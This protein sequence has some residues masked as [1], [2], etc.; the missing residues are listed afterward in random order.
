MKGQILI[1]LMLFGCCFIIKTEVIRVNLKVNGEVYEY[2]FEDWET[3]CAVADKICDDLSMR[4]EEEDFRLEGKL[5]YTYD[6]TKTLAEAEVKNGT[7]I[8]VKFLSRA[9]DLGAKLS[10][11]KLFQK[12]IKRI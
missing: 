9:R 1:T 2:D 10:G 7:T 12:P 11:G 3:L 6:F 5:L 4:C 8:K